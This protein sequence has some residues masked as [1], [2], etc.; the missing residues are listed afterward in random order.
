M[1]L[2]L[3]LVDDHRILREGLKVLLGKEPDFQIAAEA[4]D[5]SEAVRV[6]RGSPVDVIIMDVTMPELSGSEATRQILEASP[7]TKV[8]A[9]SMHRNGQFVTEMLKAGAT[10]YVVKTC[11]VEE[12]A[13]AIRAVAAGQVYLSSEVAGVVMEGYLSKTDPTAGKNGS[14]RLSPREREVLRLLAGGLSTKQAALRLGRSPKTVEMHRR[15]VME[16]L[17]LSGLAEL[18]RYAINQGLISLDT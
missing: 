7:N 16:K 13:R 1:D 5:G 18:T 6:A 11:I 12:L 9:L 2:R 8:V 3:M 17:G 10:G 4:G 15:H 14:Q